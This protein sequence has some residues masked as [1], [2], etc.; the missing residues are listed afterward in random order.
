MWG[1][2][3]VILRAVARRVGVQDPARVLKLQNGCMTARCAHAMWARK[4]EDNHVAMIAN[5]LPARVAG[6]S[7]GR[8][9]R[10]CPPRGDRRAFSVAGVCRTMGTSEKDG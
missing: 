8:H 3:V 10:T 7:G 6:D 1:G 9:R 2:I 5:R 4:H